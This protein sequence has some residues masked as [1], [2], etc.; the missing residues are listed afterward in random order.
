MVAEGTQRM[1]LRG[2]ILDAIV[3]GG[4]AGVLDVLRVVLGALPETLSIPVVVVVHLPPRSHSHVHEPLQS[5]SKLPMSQLDDKEP[6]LGGHVYFAPPGYHL[7]IESDRCAAL[8]IDEPVHYSRPSVDVLFDAA[9]DAY[10]GAL[11]GILLTGAS[12]D[13]AAGLQRIAER[14]GLT[15]VQS[16]DSAEAAAMPQAALE[17]FEPDYVL[18]P[19]AIASLLATLST[20]YTTP[21]HDS[22][23]V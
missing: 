16:P 2:H 22:H 5:A 12:P 20:L 9:S 4:S 15:I 23:R 6:L 17:L 1:R 19:S 3:I 21:S 8:S 18:A 14:G 10:G 7:L 13:G 11:L